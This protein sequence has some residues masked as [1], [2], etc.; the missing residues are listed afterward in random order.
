M[1]TLSC[2]VPNI[3]ALDLAKFLFNK[4]LLCCGGAEVVV[5]YLHE[6][7]YVDINTLS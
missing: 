6:Y 4:G 2:I 7:C 1:H 5:R 3:S